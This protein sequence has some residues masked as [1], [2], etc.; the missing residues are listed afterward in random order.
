M[1]LARELHHPLVS[2]IDTSGL[3]LSQEAEKG[4]A[5]GEIAR[6]LSELVMLEAP[7]VSLL[8]GE[9]TGGGSCRGIRRDASP[10][11]SRGTEPW[12][13]HLQ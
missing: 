12:A 5:A 6:C 11:G 2:V 13:D 3:A 1:R 10:V 4:A 7:T 8:L 9:G